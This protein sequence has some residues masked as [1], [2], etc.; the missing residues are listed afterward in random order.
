M[1]TSKIN[2]SNT[3]D[4]CLVPLFTVL[5]IVDIR[6]ELRNVLYE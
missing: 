2:L 3:C 4:F 6:A 5:V 1:N